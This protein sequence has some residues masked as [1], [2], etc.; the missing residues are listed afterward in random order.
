VLDR[1]IDTKYVGTDKKGGAKTYHISGTV[2]AAEVEAIAGSTD[3]EEP[4][5]TDV[6]IGV[7]NSIV[8]EVDIKGP[9]QPSEDPG[10]WRS[11]ILTALS[12]APEIKAPQ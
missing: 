12:V 7:D 11:I 8:Y 5:P 4:F 6:W 2:A 10:V 1:I 9:A 3:T